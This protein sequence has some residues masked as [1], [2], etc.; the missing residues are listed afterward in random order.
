MVSDKS[1]DSYTINIFFNAILWKNFFSILNYP[2]PFKELLKTT[3]TVLFH[4]QEI[5]VLNYRKY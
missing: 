3:H 4:R 2:Q 1:V 5:V